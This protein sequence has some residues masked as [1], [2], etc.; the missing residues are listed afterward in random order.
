MSS[1]SATI[2]LGLILLVALAVTIGMQQAQNRALDR[3]NE[4]NARRGRRCPHCGGWIP[5]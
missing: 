3:L 4:I 5:P 1:V 2:L